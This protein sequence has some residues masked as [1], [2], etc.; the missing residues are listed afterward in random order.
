MNISRKS[1]HYRMFE[2]T[3]GDTD[4][5][6][7]RGDYWSQVALGLAFLLIG[8]FSFGAT[9]LIAHDFLTGTGLPLPRTITYE[10]FF[11]AMSFGCM[12]FSTGIFTP[13]VNR[14]R[15]LLASEKPVRFTD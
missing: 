2:R 1:W 3:G 10:A 12:Q 14:A 13:L 9:L 8:L 5:E 6:I 7:S 11:L 4:T 15:K